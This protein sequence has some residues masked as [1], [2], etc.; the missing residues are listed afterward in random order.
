MASASRPAPPG[1]LFL[2]LLGL[3]LAG[4]PPASAADIAAEHEQLAAILR[5][6]DL[7]DRLAEQA[8]HTA[9]E[10]R[11]RYHFDYLRLHA[12]LKSV[13]TGMRDYLVPQR[14]QPRDPVPLNG[15]Y[16]GEEGSGGRR[17]GKDAP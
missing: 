8:E 10:E 4:T 7:A 17:G 14:A 11:A 15:D 5:Q 2:T 3:V 9:P 12:D 1:R 16:T 6:L 13:R